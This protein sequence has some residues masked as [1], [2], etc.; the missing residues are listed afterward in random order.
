ML[1]DHCLALFCGE[2]TKSNEDLNVYEK[3][4]QYYVSL[5]SSNG[6]KLCHLIRARIRRRILQKGQVQE[7]DTL[8]ADILIDR[9]LKFMMDPRDARRNV[10]ASLTG[11]FSS[12]SDEACALIFYKPGKSSY[13]L[14]MTHIR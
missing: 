11:Y 7:E 13:E 9:K 10:E 8:N 12:S 5:A 1:C 2:L 3:R 6:C 4:D 14:L